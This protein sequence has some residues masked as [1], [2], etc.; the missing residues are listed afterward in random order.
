MR[1]T[2]HGQATK[3]N[4]GI[5]DNM[6]MQNL[7]SDFIQQEYTYGCIHIVDQL[8]VLALVYHNSIARRGY[9]HIAGS[10]FHPPL[11]MT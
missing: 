5:C 7:S 6:Q 11:D 3:P 10:L 9:I 4:Q 2:F 8:N 1:N